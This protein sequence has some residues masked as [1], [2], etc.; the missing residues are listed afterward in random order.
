MKIKLSFFVAAEREK[1]ILFG[2]KNCIICLY[3]LKLFKFKIAHVNFSN[4]P[5]LGSRDLWVEIG[6]IDLRKLDFS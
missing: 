3:T 5:L 1:S 2:F 4:N 6:F